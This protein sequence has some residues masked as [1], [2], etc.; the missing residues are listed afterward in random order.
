METKKG[1]LQTQRKKHQCEESKTPDAP[2]IDVATDFDSR[3][4]ACR[5]FCRCGSLIDGR[6]FRARW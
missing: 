5:G 6:R 2:S 1:D 4:V 3:E